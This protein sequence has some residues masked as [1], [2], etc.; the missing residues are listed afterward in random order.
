MSTW[1]ELSFKLH[2][3]ASE[4]LNAIQPITATSVHTG[5]DVSLVAFACALFIKGRSNIL[6]VAMSVWFRS[7]SWFAAFSFFQAVQLLPTISV[8]SSQ[9]V[10][11]LAGVPVILLIKRTPPVSIV[12]VIWFAS[13]WS[14]SLT[15]S[16]LFDSEQTVI[17]TRFTVSVQAIHVFATT[18]TCG[19]SLLVEALPPVSHSTALW[20]SMGIAALFGQPCTFWSSIRWSWTVAISVL[21]PSITSRWAR[22][23]WWVGTIYCRHCRSFNLNVAKHCICSRVP[24]I[25]GVYLHILENCWF[26]CFQ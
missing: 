1:L 21:V 15:A 17:T 19:P 13:I 22:F 23:P 8:K 26:F 16:C 7:G 14:W 10:T 4:F 9:E 5:H 3:A 20:T 25:R 18:S 24:W 12:T 11:S 6:V 2:L